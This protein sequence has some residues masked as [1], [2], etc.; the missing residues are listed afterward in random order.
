MLSWKYKWYWMK[1]ARIKTAD[2]N[3]KRLFRKAAW[4]KKQV[5]L[6][7]PLSFSSLR[8]SFEFLLWDVE[9]VIWTCTVRNKLEYHDVFLTLNSILRKCNFWTEPWASFKESPLFWSWF[10]LREALLKSPQEQYCSVVFFWIV[11]QLRVSTAGFK[12][13]TTLNNF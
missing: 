8:R 9:L 11:W 4:C 7:K 5:L 1:K 6:F 2:Y 10:L 13:R 3:L 12:V